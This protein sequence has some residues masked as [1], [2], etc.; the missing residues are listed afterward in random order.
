MKNLTVKNSEGVQVL[1]NVSFTARGGE[2]LGIAGISGSGQK[3]LLE[4]IA[5]LQYAEPGSSVVYHSPEGKEFQLI[6]MK[7]SDIQNLGVHMSFVPEDRLGMGLVGST[8][9]SKIK[10]EKDKEELKEEKAESN[11]ESEDDE[12]QRRKMMKY[13]SIFDDLLKVNF[14]INQIIQKKKEKLENMNK[15]DGENDPYSYL[16]N[17]YGF[18]RTNTSFMP[19]SYLKNLGN[20]KV[21]KVKTSKAKIVNFYETVRAQLLNIILRNIEIV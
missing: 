8:D 9:N 21:N 11:S 1:K 19:D 4:A 17:S 5:G 14:K 2:I 13:G 10:E 15:S 7:P 20:K 16:H 18:P 3:E 6:G 12:E